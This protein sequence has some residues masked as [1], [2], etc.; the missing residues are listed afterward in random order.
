[1]L[2]FVAQEI[3]EAV[4]F[5]EKAVIDELARGHT[6]SASYDWRTSIWLDFSLEGDVVLNSDF[7]VGPSPAFAS[8]VLKDNPHEM[9]LLPVV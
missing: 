7:W 9:V 3:E 8:F 5:D 4:I 2:P 6:I 1:M